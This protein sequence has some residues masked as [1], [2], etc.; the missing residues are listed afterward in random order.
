MAFAVVWETTFRQYKEKYMKN[1]IKI[2]G[3][4]ALFTLVSFSILS[5][6]AGSGLQ[7]KLSLQDG[8]KQKSSPQL[9][10]WGKEM[11]KWGEKL[12]QSLD[13]GQPIPPV[14][15]IPPFDT[16]DF[17]G[18][19]PK[20]G[21]YLED[22][23]FE[24]AY[25]MHYPNCYGVLIT[26]VVNGGNADRAGLVKDDIIMEFDGQKVRYES[27]LLNLRDSKKVGDTVPITFFRNETVMTTELTFAGVEKED[28][29]YYETDEN[30]FGMGRK[31]SPGYGGGFIE[32]TRIDYNFD[33]INNLIGGY[34][35]GPVKDAIFIGGGGMGNIG[36]GWFIGGKGA[37]FKYNKNIPHNTEVPNIPDSTLN[38]KRT[39]NIES[40]FGGVTIVKKIALFSPKVV[41]DIGTM[42][43]GGNTFLEIAQTDGNYSWDETNLNNGINWYAKYEKSYVVINPSVGLLVR[44][45]NWLGLQAAYGYL[46][47][48]SIDEQWRERPFDFDVSGKSPEVPNGSTVSAG[49]WFGF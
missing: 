5:A 13:N 11:D 39:L 32:V 41:L 1:I 6:G 15:P 10:E 9:E 18:Q 12:E 49:I 42:L 46:Y 16:N 22:L 8:E 27:H 38:V 4:V 30:K 31:L 29:K 3:I 21:L 33:V 7:L 45:N 35:F 14:P 24:E 47:A 44:I 19:S 43:G 40:G 37:G 20:L 48:W 26:G 28:A 23:D 2:T 17:N 25:K 36:N 34:G